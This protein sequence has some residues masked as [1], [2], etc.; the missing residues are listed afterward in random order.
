MFKY[1]IPHVLA[2]KSTATL[3]LVKTCYLFNSNSKNLYN[4]VLNTHYFI[5]HKY[6]KSK[7]NRKNNTDPNNHD[8]TKLNC[9]FLR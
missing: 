5:T 6:K 2:K 8:F 7:E 1:F 9:I 4:Y 3:T